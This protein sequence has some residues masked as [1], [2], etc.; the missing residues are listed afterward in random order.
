MNVKEE[1]KQ[2]I[3]NLSLPLIEIDAND[4][5]NKDHYQ[6]SGMFFVKT[7]DGCYHLVEVDAGNNASELCLF[8]NVV[9]EFTKKMVELSIRDEMRSMITSLAESIRGEFET[10]RK[11]FNSSVLHIY[12]SVDKNKDTIIEKLE[13]LVE[14]L[15]QA[16]SEDTSKVLQGYI[17][18]SAL[19]DVLRTIK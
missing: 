11:E 1:K 6:E 8:P 16:P 4:A 2:V 9:N 17:S 19:V 3:L 5:W 7:K 15:K 14:K 10:S 12:E 18:E 13:E